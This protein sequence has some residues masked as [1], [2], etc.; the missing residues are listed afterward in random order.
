MA[1][2]LPMVHFGTRPKGLGFVVPRG[3]KWLLKLIVTVPR[4]F[5]MTR[6]RKEGGIE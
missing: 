6:E 2:D 3:E 4:I 5:P 1:A